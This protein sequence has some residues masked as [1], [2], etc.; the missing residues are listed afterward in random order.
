VASTIKAASLLAAGRAAGV[1]SAKVAA[2]TE[3]VVQAMRLTKTKIATVVVLMIAALA[4]ATLLLCQTQAADPPKAKEE[5]PASRKEQKGEEKQP[6]TKEEKLRVL[7]D[8]VLA[9]HG[10]EDKLNKLQFTMTAKHSN[11]TTIQYFVQPPNHGRWEIQHRDSK[12]KRICILGPQGKMWWEKN[13]NEQAVGIFYTGLELPKEFNLDYYVTFFGPRQ[14]LRLKDAKH[15]VTLVDE[16]A[17]IDG[18]AAVGVEVA[19]PWFKGTM[20]FDK[21][22]HLLVK[23]PAVWYLAGQ[24]AATYSDYKTFDGIPMPQ[25]EN[26]GYL[27][28]QVTDFRVV[29]KFDPKLFKQP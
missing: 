17:M 27:M 3:G 1:V 4:G 9:A 19:G 18:R 21:E 20:Y 11:G 13:P 15:R 16:E 6:M 29:D 8:Q 14:V 12:T 26:D 23:S 25:K 22:T 24:G 7:I 2:L 5:Q 10:G 28:A